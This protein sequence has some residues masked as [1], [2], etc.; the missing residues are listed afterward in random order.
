MLALMIDMATSGFNQIQYDLT[1]TDAT[2]SC[3]CVHTW[4]I[5]N[6]CSTNFHYIPI[7]PYA[8]RIGACLSF[9]IDDFM[10]AGD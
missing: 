3:W 10:C 4:N 5:L 2:I 6:I 9:T 1:S 7:L 8:Y